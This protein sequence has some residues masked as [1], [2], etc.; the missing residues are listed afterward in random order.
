M[1]KIRFIPPRP[2][3]VLYAF[4]RPGQSMLKFFVSV[5]QSTPVTLF[6]ALDGRMICSW[7]LMMHT[8]FKYLLFSYE[9]VNIKY[10][11]ISCKQGSVVDKTAVAEAVAGASVVYHM[12]SYGMSGKSQVSTLVCYPKRI[13]KCQKP[14][15]ASHRKLSQIFFFANLM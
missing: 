10:F 2:N 9:S 5:G 7:F 12:A 3:S 11:L 8:I 15:V 1:V 13:T 14:K 6:Y 4:F